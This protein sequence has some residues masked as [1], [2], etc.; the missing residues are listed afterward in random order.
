MQPEFDKISSRK[1]PNIKTVAAA[2]GVSTATVSNAFN[3]PDQLSPEVRERVLAIAR[4]LGYSGAN[5]VARNL[6]RMSTN[7]IGFV[8]SES[9]EFGINDPASQQFLQGIARALESRGLGLLLLPYS[10]TANS[11]TVRDAAVDGII[12]YCPPINTPLVQVVKDRRLP[13]VFVDYPNRLDCTTVRVRDRSGARGLAEHL[14]QLGHKRC[15]PSSWPRESAEGRGQR[16]HR[17]SPSCAGRRHRGYHIRLM[18]ALL[19]V[20]H[21]SKQSRRRPLRGEFIQ[22]L[23]FL[24]VP[25]GPY[26]LNPLTVRLSESARE[27]IHLLEISNQSRPSRAPAQSFLG[28]SA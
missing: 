13:A 22:L 27:I 16:E 9:L 6:R 5:P 26:F 25:V 23:A 11:E 4:E 7:T 2:A 14:I 18:A 17:R 12:L 21:C 19:R 28:L 24:L 15:R 3:R 8:Y 10:A 1:K 20:I